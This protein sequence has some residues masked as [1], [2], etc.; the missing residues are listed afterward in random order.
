MGG[1]GGGGGG[2]GVNVREEEGW[3]WVKRCARA[4]IGGEKVGTRRGG[5]GGIAEHGANV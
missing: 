4:W 2:G 3:S 5:R 1:G